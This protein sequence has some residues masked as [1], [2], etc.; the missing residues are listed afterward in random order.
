MPQLVLIIEDDLQLGRQLVERLRK[1]GY[2]TQW[3]T[4]GRAITAQTVPAV[5]LVVLD[6]M[7]PGVA[8]LD[9][10]KQL[11]ERSEVPVLVL[12]ARN[13]TRDKVRALQLGADDYM[14]KPFWPEELVA[15][16]RARLRRPGLLRDGR[17]E[18]GELVIDLPARRVLLGDREIDLTRAEFNLLAALARRAGEAL[19]R[20]A[21][22]EASLDGE[23]ESGDRALDIHVSRLRRMLGPAAEAV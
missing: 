11:R 16:V 21:L 7:L 6:L 17:I 12:S 13:D 23:A 1:A 3:W 18:R 14:T 8:G 5:D 19:T 20:H 2:A 22:V 15:R 10:L 4:E 9:L